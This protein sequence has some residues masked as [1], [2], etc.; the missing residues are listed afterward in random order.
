MAILEDVQAAMPDDGRVAYYLGNLYY[1]KKRYDEAIAQW[2]H[3]AEA[4]PGFS[5]PWRNLGIAHYNV[6]HDART[7][8]DCYEKAFAANPAD[9]RVLSELDQLRARTGTAAEERL[10]RLERRLDLVRARDDLSVVLARLYNR[11]QQPQ[12]ALDYML[13]RRFHPWEGGTGS[14]GG[15]YVAAHLQLGRAALDA[16]DAET[17]LN[18]LDAARAPYPENLG[19]R[20]H[21]LWPDAEVHY[22]TGLAQR[23]LGDEAGAQARFEHVLSTRGGLSAVGYYQAL[24]LRA[25]GREDEAATRLEELLDGARAQLAEQAARGFATSVPQFVFVEDDLETRRRLQ[26][27]YV[28]GLAHRGLGEMDRARAA[29]EAVLALNANHRGALAQLNQL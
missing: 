22:V 17:A 6:R 2:E 5:I 8:I 24:A 16:G 3:A 1:D 9:G 4:E 12:R 20:K 19:E 18:H 28:I 7:A 29:F 26:L 25:L 15:E 21:L 27:N 23:A 10:S 11:A 14:I 13:S